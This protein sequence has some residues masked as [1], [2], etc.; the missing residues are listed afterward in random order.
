[1]TGASPATSLPPRR[2]ALF[3]P[4]PA[5][6][7]DARTLVRR[8]LADQGREDA[9]DG[10]V[11]CVSELVTNA[12]VH[13]GTD[14]RLRVWA[15]PHGVR[16][17]VEDGSGHLPIPRNYANLAATGRGLMMVDRTADR[18][19]VRSGPESKVVWFELGEPL[20][21]DQR[22]LREGTAAERSSAHVDVVLLNL[23]LVLH[24]AWQMHAES[25]LREL[26]L[27]R[28]DDE[29]SMAHLEA[30]AHATDAIAVLES[31]IEEPDLGGDS[32]AIM[33]AATEPL[34]TLERHVVRVP[35][36]A[37]PHFETL[38]ALL[39]EALDLV[40]AGRLFTP[41]TQP[42]IRAFRTWVCDEVR[43]QAAGETPTAWDADQ[44]GEAEPSSPSVSWDLREIETAEAAAVAADD[45]GRIVAISVE[46]ARLLG[47]GSAEDV[48]GRRLTAII[49]ARFRQAH[50]AGVTLHVFAGRGPLLG[51][52]VVVPALCADGSETMI[53]VL[54]RSQENHAGRRLF[55][56]VFEPAPS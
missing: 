49:P 46:A 31:Q 47:F 18:W 24:R 32:E 52:P 35:E 42:E 30:H 38:R 16:V 28:L 33:A 2:E 19:G 10:S 13:A 37:L 17:E 21:V 4:T 27:V 26:L 44:V 40:Q 34:V 48:V 23:P 20:E 6:V 11:L 5:S 56:A 12:V 51:T 43:R 22:A 7:A 15:E 1:M 41:A 45:T 29:D 39:D 25:L 3:P 14:V 9:L 36:R 54:V 53:Q 50:L 55:T 8:V